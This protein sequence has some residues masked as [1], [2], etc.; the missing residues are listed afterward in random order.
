MRTK[1]RSLAQLRDI[2]DDRSLPLRPRIEAA[3][4]CLQYEGAASD[5]YEFLQAVGA[6]TEVHLSFRLLALKYAAEYE[7]RRKPPPAPLTREN[8]LTGIG[9]RLDRARRHRLRVIEG[10]PAA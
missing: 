1:S 7:Q 9:E 10:D 3:A 6:E 4:L 8:E 2:Y 5:A